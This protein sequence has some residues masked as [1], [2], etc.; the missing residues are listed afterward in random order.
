MGFVAGKPA[1]SIT[2]GHRR[3]SSVAS[4][5]QLC[6][7]L[8]FR[9]CLPREFLLVQSVP[10]EVQAPEEPAPAHQVRVPETA[11]IQVRDLQQVFH[12]KGHPQGPLGQA[13]EVRQLHG[14]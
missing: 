13:L 12:A 4:A 2:C 9:F 3:V 5:I 11:A 14:C 8:S 6:G 1:I 10:Q 7:S